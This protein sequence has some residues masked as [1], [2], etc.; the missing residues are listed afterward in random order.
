MNF[1]LNFTPFRRMIRPLSLYLEKTRSEDPD[2]KVKWVIGEDIRIFGYQQPDY[3]TRL[4]DIKLNKSSTPVLNGD[5]PDFLTEVPTTRGM[6]TAIGGDEIVIEVGPG[7]DYL[8]IRTDDFRY[9]I[10]KSWETRDLHLEESYLPMKQIKIRG[11]VLATALQN[12]VRVAPSGPLR[13]K[14]SND[15]VKFVSK[16][17]NDKA[18]LDITNYVTNYSNNEENEYLYNLY[19]LSEELQKFPRKDQIELFVNDKLIRFRYEIGDNLGYI[20]YYQQGK[21]DT[22]RTSQY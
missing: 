20:N 17:D 22:S 13:L 5:Y 11:S 16:T 18:V 4:T 21:V 8:T 7:Q 6:G 2:V 3:Q 12:Y 14:I 9:N 1:R 10:R 15:T 19:L